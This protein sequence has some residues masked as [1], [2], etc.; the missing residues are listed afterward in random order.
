MHV[1]VFVVRD[2]RVAGASLV[3]VVGLT[4]SVAGARCRVTLVAPSATTELRG[5]PFVPLEGPCR[6]LS[7]AA[8]Y[9]AFPTA[10][11]P[12]RWLP[13]DRALTGL[14]GAQGFDMI[15]CHQHQAG[16]RLFKI[17]H[18]LAMPVALDV[19]GIIRIQ[20]EDHRATA[21]TPWHVAML[22]RMERNVF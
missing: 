11:A 19:H 6:G 15:H 18:R 8:P 5:V 10:C 16:F 9:A 1:G 14:L 4:Q 2:M 12:L 20:E 22:L 7:L 3:R 13:A 21:R 17:R